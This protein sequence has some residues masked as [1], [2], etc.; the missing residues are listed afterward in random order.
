MNKTHMA[1]IKAQKTPTVTV[2]LGKKRQVCLKLTVKF[3]PLLC[4]ISLKEILVSGYNKTKLKATCRGRTGTSSDKRNKGLDNSSLNEWAQSL[5]VQPG[6]D[7]RNCSLEA[8]KDAL[9]SFSN[10]YFFWPVL[11]PLPA[12]PL[13][14][15]GADH[16]NSVLWNIH[17]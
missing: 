6:R 1:V 14:K 15:D 2:G 4:L 12:Q 5:W 10:K 17:H 8:Q 7:I 9:T 3:H 16:A 13:Q 11:M